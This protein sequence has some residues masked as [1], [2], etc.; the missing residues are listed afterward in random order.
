MESV[1]P[2]HNRLPLV[3]RFI[4]ITTLL[5]LGLF[6]IGRLDGAEQDVF[7]SDVVTFHGD[8]KVSVDTLT[9]G[10][11]LVTLACKT[12]DSAQIPSNYS[13]ILRNV[14]PIEKALLLEPQLSNGGWGRFNLF[15]AAMIVEGVRDPKL[16]ETYEA[17]LDALVARV[18][19]DV[20]ASGNA[21]P[22]AL[23]R[24][25]FETMHKE[26]LT[27]PYS[28]DC[29]E[30]GKVMQTGHFNCVSATVLFNVLA[31]KAGLDVCA[32]E[33]PGHAL[34]MVRFSDG[35]TM[36]IET[37]APTWF[38]LQ[39]DKERQWATQQRIAPA[40][41]LTNPP[42]AQNVAAV[43]EVLTEADLT[44]QHREIN[45][46]QL[47]ATIYY[48]IGVDLHAKKRYPEAVAANL[49]ALFLDKKNEQAWT[50]LLASLNN[51][52][53]DL[54][55]ESKGSRYKEAAVI[56]DQ[57]VAIDPTYANFRANQT[58]VFYHWIYG[59]AAKGRFDDARQV[60]A[61]VKERR[62]DNENFQKLMSGIDLAEEK[63]A[64]QRQ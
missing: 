22:Q 51:W 34:S 31:E 60:Y 11:F 52:A 10:S 33:M 44:V 15:R 7:R 40:P 8:Q 50:N 42:T 5:F 45:P 13:I 28:I 36:K 29:T 49:K 20:R 37:T 26:I 61:S 25:M 46:V 41:A 54:A 16:I 62:L 64:Q 59:L 18:I 4:M 55:S 53:L 39:S 58:F 9:G 63:L 35:A 23:T 56:L 27:K 30:L 6:P 32:L 14:D 3:A 1:F 38:S 19:A 43:P 47:V 21:S 17:R 24:H 2:S 48:N 12:A 57:G